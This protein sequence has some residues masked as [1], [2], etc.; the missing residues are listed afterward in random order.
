MPEFAQVIT[1]LALLLSSVDTPQRPSAAA[2]VV[3]RVPVLMYHVI[4]DPPAG[5]PWPQLYVSGQEFTAQMTWLDRNGYTAVTLS[6]VWR[7]WHGR[8]PLPSRPVVLTFDDG[9]RS[10]YEEALP[11]LSPLGWPAVLNLKVDN[12]FEPWGISPERVREFVAAGWEIA[13]HTITHPDL[14]TLDTASL[15]RESRARERSWLDGSTRRWT[16]SAIPLAPTTSACSRR[17][18]TRAFSGRRPQSRAS[19]RP[20]PRSR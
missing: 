7:N 5:A 6:D 20:T 12:L 14:R 4:A 8:V 13:A 16:S 17:S 9:Y 3:A 19:P 2:P 15:E 11:L 1:A 10:V 18:G